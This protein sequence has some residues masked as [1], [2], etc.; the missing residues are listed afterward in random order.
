MKWIAKG[1]AW[2]YVNEDDSVIDRVIYESGVYQS[3][4]H[5]RCYV[6][7]N[8]IKKYIE[9]EHAKKVGEIVE[10]FTLEEKPDYV[11][12]FLKIVTYAVL[13]ILFLVL[14]TIIFCNKAHAENR[15]ITDI[16]NAYARQPIVIV[17]QPNNLYPNPPAYLPPVRGQVLEQADFGGARL[18]ETQPI[19]LLG[20]G[21][22]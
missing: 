4:R 3:M 14:F 1:K 10:C 5:T 20:D 21:D 12:S 15:A 22:E 11:V 17:V 6:S 7:L 13:T 9:L 2:L 8:G 19:N 16:L 18:H